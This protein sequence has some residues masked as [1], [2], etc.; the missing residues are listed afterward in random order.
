MRLHSYRPRARKRAWIARSEYHQRRII[1]DV[2]K[3]FSDFDSAQPEA[4]VFGKAVDP[5]ARTTQ[6]RTRRISKHDVDEEELTVVLEVLLKRSRKDRVLLSWSTATK[7]TNGPSP[8]YEEKD[9]EENYL[10]GA[11]FFQKKHRVVYCDKEEALFDERVPSK[12]MRNKWIP[13]DYRN[14]KLVRQLT[15]IS[16]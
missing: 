2:Q 15:S 1:R 5:A 13:V 14:N 16:T 12:W 7:E 4:K 8:G 6:K 9:E 10:R 3:V 11:D